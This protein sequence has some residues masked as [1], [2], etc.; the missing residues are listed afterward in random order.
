MEYNNDV[1]TNF[2]KEYKCAVNNLSYVTL[3]ELSIE[4]WNK[5]LIDANNLYTKK[6]N[7][8]QAIKTILDDEECTEVVKLL[9]QLYE[10]VNYVKRKYEEKILTDKLNL[11]KIYEV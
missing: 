11:T 6:R 1:F 5:K 9:F 4:E 2:L 10:Y 3:D 8:F 7:N